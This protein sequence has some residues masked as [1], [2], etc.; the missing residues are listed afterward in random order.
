MKF[1]LYFSRATQRLDV[2]AKFSEQIQFKRYIDG[3]INDR[4]AFSSYL[5][6][7]SAPLCYDL[8]TSFFSTCQLLHIFS[9][10]KHVVARFY[11]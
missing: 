6:D 5:N 7:F 11:P 9:R 10:S 2:Y 4:L 8:L 3:E 1:V